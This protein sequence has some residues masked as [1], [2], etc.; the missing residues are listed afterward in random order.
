MSRTRQWLGTALI[1]ALPIASLIVIVL[2]VAMLADSPA[3]SAVQVPSNSGATAQAPADAATS[4]QAP[5]A[6]ATAATGQSPATTA[7][8]DARVTR[9]LEDRRRTWRDMNVPESDGRALYDIV[10]KNGYKQALEIG[11]S[12]GLS[13]IHTAW[14]LAKTGG[15]LITVE[16]D[17][18]RHRE[19][20]TNFK[21]AGLASFIDARL[22]D[23]HDLVPKLE[24]PFDF[25][26][27]DA[28][29]EWYVNYA[30]AVLPKLKSGGCIAAHN[31]SAGGGWRRSMGGDYYAFITSQPNMETTVING[32]LAISYKK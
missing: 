13:G 29:K 5:A 30:K 7:D 11:T 25:V 19:A 3:A 22:A 24:G 8:L 9:F 31:V 17:E 32:Q 18:G 1:L 4:A 6:R 21:E 12:T 23:A 2:S 20:I 16:I 27:I 26:F 14:A 15:K 10:L 28:D